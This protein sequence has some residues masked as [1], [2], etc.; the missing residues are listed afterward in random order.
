MKIGPP[1]GTLSLMQ[2]E[3]PQPG[4][5]QTQETCPIGI[6][7]PEHHSVFCPTCSS[8]L[9]ESR[10]KLICRNCGYFLSCADFY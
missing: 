5:S 9:S 7:Q 3:Q 10:C 2:T 4:A 1:Y 8:R 6:D